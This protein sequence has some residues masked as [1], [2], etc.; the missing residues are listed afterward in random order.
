MDPGE[1]H[2]DAARR[3]ILEETGLEVADVGARIYQENIP[4]PYDDAIFPGAHQEFFAVP[5][6]AEFEPDR[7]GWTESEHVD[8]TKWAWWSLE[9][10][11][12]TSEPYEPRQLP[13]IM[14]TL[15]N[16]LAKGH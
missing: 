13:D 11:R 6:S 4:L 5:V 16:G 10:L 8:V 3:E 14:N 1:T 2:E 7:S 9:E 15:F 12:A